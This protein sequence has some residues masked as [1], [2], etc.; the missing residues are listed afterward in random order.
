M[1]DNETFVIH[2]GTYQR[3]EKAELMELPW[4]RECLASV[5]TGAILFV[6]NTRGFKVNSI[7]DGGAIMGPDL[8]SPPIYIARYKKPDRFYIL[9]MIRDDDG[10]VELEPYQIT[11]IFK[12]TVSTNYIDSVGPRVFSNGPNVWQYR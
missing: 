4:I 9:E 11:R 6:N 10:F 12:V 3:L 5:S 1:S 8:T 7:N 2:S